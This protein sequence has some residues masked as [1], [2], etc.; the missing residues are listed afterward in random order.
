M[1][2][3]GIFTDIHYAQAKQYGKRYCYLSLKKLKHISNIFNQENL[4]FVVCLGDTIDSCA[5][6]Q[7]D[8]SNLRSAVECLSGFD[9]PL[10]LVLGN[11]DLEA[12]SKHAFLTAIGEQQ[13]KPYYSFSCGGTLFILLDCN[14]LSTGE[15]CCGN[16]EWTDSFLDETQL[17]W[18]KKTLADSDERNIIIF[19]HQNLDDRLKNGKK[20]PHVITNSADVRKTLESSGKAITVFQGHDHSGFDQTINGIRYLTLRA[21]S[22]GADISDAPYAVVTIDVKRCLNS[23]N[24]SYI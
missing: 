7:T 10:H 13:R 9:A 1:T 6:E 3:I 19:T 11:H 24:L 20:D 14:N 18:L 23:V 15:Y 8:L 2:K 12:M 4:D 5:D 17:N 16:F 21:V 22:D